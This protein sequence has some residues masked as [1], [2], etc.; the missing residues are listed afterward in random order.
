[1]ATLYHRLDAKGLEG[2]PSMLSLP[3]HLSR[4]G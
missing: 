3:V 2:A 4:L 1:M